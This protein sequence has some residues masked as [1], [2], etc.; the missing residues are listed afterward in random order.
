MAK[1]VLLFCHCLTDSQVSEIE[2]LQISSRPACWLPLTLAG[3]TANDPWLSALPTLLLYV[4]YGTIWFARL[5]GVLLASNPV[6]PD[7]LST[8][9]S[10]RLWIRKAVATATR[11]ISF[12]FTEFLKLHSYAAT[13]TVF[14]S[15]L[16][17]FSYESEHL[18]WRIALELC[19]LSACL[20]A[21]PPWLHGVADTG[22][23]KEASSNLVISSHLPVSWATP[24]CKTQYVKPSN[25]QTSSN[26]FCR[27]GQHLQLAWETQC[28][29]RF[30]QFR[31]FLWEEPATSSS[32]NNNY[33]HWFEQDKH[34]PLARMLSSVQP[35]QDHV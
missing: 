13:H 16:E 9:P 6:L 25:H 33:H 27:K 35:C 20:C 12:A 7:L 3:K 10:A 11:I 24:F 32:K 22:G 28:G 4:F 21:K 29:H 31:L 17:W 23:A 2:P 34:R 26:P 14:K 8:W 1:A 19:Y 30:W 18:P 15:N 5:C